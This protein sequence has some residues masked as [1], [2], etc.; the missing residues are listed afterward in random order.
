[1][2]TVVPVYDG[3]PL[4]CLQVEEYLGVNSGVGT[5]A[6]PSLYVARMKNQHG[7]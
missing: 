7:H 6:L 1:M 5:T 2:N 3:M 4:R